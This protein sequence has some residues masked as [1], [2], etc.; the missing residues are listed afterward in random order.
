MKQL[1]A[2]EKGTQDADFFSSVSIDLNL[3]LGDK[4]LLSQR[5]LMADLFM[6]VFGTQS[7]A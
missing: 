5:H 4:H 3:S 7:A 2:N 6:K 1:E